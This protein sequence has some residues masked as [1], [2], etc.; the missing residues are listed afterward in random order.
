MKAAEKGLGI[1]G[2]DL[3]SLRNIKRS[4]GLHHSGVGGVMGREAGEV[5]GADIIDSLDTLRS[6]PL[7]LRAMG[8]HCKVLLLPILRFSAEE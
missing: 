4:A 8:S 7:T 5:A 6:L 2:S 1:T 3:E